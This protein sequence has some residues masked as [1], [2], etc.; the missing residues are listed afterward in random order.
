MININ[1]LLINSVLLGSDTELEL[2]TIKLQKLE[3]TA[4]PSKV[5]FLRARKVLKP[6]ESNQ[7]NINDRTHKLQLLN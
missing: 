4:Q 2:V 6:D 5:E 3:I 1:I 7:L